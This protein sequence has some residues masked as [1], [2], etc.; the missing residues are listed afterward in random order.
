MARTILAISGIFCLQVAFI[1]YNLG[2]PAAEQS[3]V[4]TDAAATE[5]LMASAIDSPYT[6][7]VAAAEL[8]QTDFDTVSESPEVGDPRVMRAAAAEPERS[9]VRRARK[10]VL[11]TFVENAV[12]SSPMKIRF[13]TYNAVAFR[14]RPG[15]LSIGRTEYPQLPNAASEPSQLQASTKDAPAKKRG[16]FRK[17]LKVIT[18]P[19]DWLKTVGAALK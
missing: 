10:P 6:G 2:D 9:V 13:K 15:A 18:K 7:T 16:F 5:S 11:N 14:E 19:Y 17:S 1:G 3:F 8:D 12:V 4:R